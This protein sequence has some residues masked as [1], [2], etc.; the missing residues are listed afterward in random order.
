MPPVPAPTTSNQL[1]PLR[2]AGKQASLRL[3]YCQAVV[4]GAETEPERS[5]RQHQRT[6]FDSVAEHYEAS[7]LSYPEEI[8]E[9]AVATAGLVAGSASS[10]SAATLASS[11][12]PWRASDS[13]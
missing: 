8:V 9:F 7:R 3:P 4:M 13:A 2:A 12:N 10:R 1:L 5:K 6:L 11:P